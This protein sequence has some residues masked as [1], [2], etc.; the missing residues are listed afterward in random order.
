LYESKGLATCLEHHHVAPGQPRTVDADAAHAALPDR[1]DRDG[2]A[3]DRAPAAAC[4]DHGAAARLA[5]ARDRQRHLLRDARR[6]RL[7]RSGL[8]RPA[9]STVYRWFAA[10]RDG[11]V[12]ERIN[13][14]LVIADRE[15]LGREAS[16]SAAI[17][18]GLNPGTSQ[19]VKTTEAGSDTRTSTPTAGHWS[20]SRIRPASRTMTAP[21][22]RS[23]LRAPWSRS[24]NACSPMPHRITRGSP[25]PPP[26]SSRSSASSPISSASS[27]SRAAGRSS[28]A[29]PAS[30]A[31]AGSP[32]AC[33][34]EG[35]GL[36]G[37]RRL[38]ARLPLRRF[39]H[40]PR[41]PQVI[42][43]A[44]AFR[45]DRGQGTAGCPGCKDLTGGPGTNRVPG[46][47]SATGEVR[48]SSARPEDPRTWRRRPVVARSCD[49][50]AASTPP[51]CSGRLGPYEQAL[52]RR[53][54]SCWQTIRASRMRGRCPGLG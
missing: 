44:A 2:L 43:W 47:L 7:A 52:V 32:R 45:R 8:G 3:P 17:I 28:A 49:S 54:Q 26:W 14:A 18:P 31:T 15:R 22:R 34:G 5:D 23:R 24:S 13:H 50:P 48:V 53:T 6:H 1:S 10:W 12:F 33:P 19:S 35:R 9:W 25:P 39:R 4:P 42:H 38:R 30:A 16:P 11:G 41:P 51:A 21:R 20:R 27:C 29:S 37:D 36:Q 46:A 40:A